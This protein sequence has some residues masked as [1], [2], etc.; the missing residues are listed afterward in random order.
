[1]KFS[2]KKNEILG[3]NTSVWNDGGYCGS[4]FDRLDWY[5]AQNVLR[6]ERHPPKILKFKVNIN[7]ERKKR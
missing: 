4:I 5:L 3:W 1:M 2:I 6:W 7:A